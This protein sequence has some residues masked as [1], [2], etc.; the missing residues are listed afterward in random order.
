[1]ETLNISVESIDKNTDLNTAAVKFSRLLVVEDKLDKIRGSFATNLHFHAVRCFEAQNKNPRDAL[2]QFEMEVETAITVSNAT[3]EEQGR[4]VLKLTGNHAFA[5]AYKRICGALSLGGNLVDPFKVETVTVK[6]K[7]DKDVVWNLDEPLDFAPL[8]TSNK[9]QEYVKKVNA[10]HAQY[11][12]K[13]RRKDLGL[14]EVIEGPTAVD[15][16]PKKDDKIG[17]LMEELETNCRNLLAEYGE[18]QMD[19]VENMIEAAIG[20]VAK[21]AAALAAQKSVAKAS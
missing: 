20:K 5:N 13:Q 11:E 14:P 12:K 4:A 10:I 7:D 9:C 2:T 18:G 6:D 21:H 15:T 16:Q 3:A 19:N 8:S 17:V 1:M